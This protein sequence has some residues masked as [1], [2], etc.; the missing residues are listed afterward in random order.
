MGD[1]IMNP[2]SRLTPEEAEVLYGRLLSTLDET[3]ALLR[4]NGGGHWAVWALTARSEILAGDA[5]GLQR[6]LGTY[7]G[8]GSFNDLVLNAPGHVNDRLSQLRTLLHDDALA[9]KRD[10]GSPD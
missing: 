2:E 4:D 9:L 7:G 8:M 5:L 6:V 3:A 1:H 10:L